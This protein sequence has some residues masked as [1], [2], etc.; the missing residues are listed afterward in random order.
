MSCRLFREIREKLGLA[1]DIHSYVSHFMDSGSLVVYGGVSPNNVES[2]VQAVLAELAKLKDQVVP[3]SELLKAKEMAK[4]R[5][6]LRMED[7]RSVSSWNGGQEIL[8]GRIKSVDEMVAIIESVSTADI[9]RVSND[10]FRSSRLNLA[11]VG[12]DLKENRLREL[13]VL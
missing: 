8:L 12:P 11:A 1:Y 3:E 6:L 2:L 5:L 13:L 4:G 7:S 10:L 9:K